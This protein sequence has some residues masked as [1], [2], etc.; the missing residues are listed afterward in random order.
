MT[1]ILTEK[2]RKPKNGKS[3]FRKQ[4]P[5]HKKEAKRKK[6][7][8]TECHEEVTGIEEHYDNIHSLEQYYPLLYVDY[9]NVV[10]LYMYNAH[11][12]Y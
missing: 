10:S 7:K 6:I 12:T 11:S 4:L 8:C 2:T 9:A 5:N 1:P 3:Q